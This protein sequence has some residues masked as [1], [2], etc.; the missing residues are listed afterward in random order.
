MRW[1][2]Q[3]WK[4]IRLI[5]IIRLRGNKT[6]FPYGLVVRIPAFHAGGPGSIPGVGTFCSVQHNYTNANV[7]FLLQWYDLMKRASKIQIKLF[8]KFK[9]VLITYQRT[10]LYRFIITLTHMVAWPSGLRRWF[11]APVSSEAW[12]RIPPLPLKLLVVLM[13]NDGIIYE[14]LVWMTVIAIWQ[15]LIPNEVLYS[16]NKMRVKVP[17][18]FE[19]G[20]L[21]SKSRV[22]TIT[23]RNQL[24]AK[25]GNTTSKTNDQYFDQDQNCLSHPSD[26]NH[27]KY[28]G[29]W[30]T[31]VFLSV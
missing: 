30:P 4:E 6:G 12:V 31:G 10:T 18:R 8:E 19:L 9:G 16:R 25:A 15:V 23:P 17:P 21:D 24:P 14:V 2:Y 7:F 26:K 3:S 27:S 13:C 28:R 11:K 22:L 5:I 1:S 29:M 20:S